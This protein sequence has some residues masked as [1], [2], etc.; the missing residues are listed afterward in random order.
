MGLALVSVMIYPDKTE[1]HNKK[2]CKA[3]EAR[4]GTRRYAV[5]HRV[6][7]KCHTRFSFTIPAYPRS[8]DPANLAG[9]RSY[10]SQ[11]CIS[12]IIFT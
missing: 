3:R 2:G 7:P 10:S 1:M 8:L 9:M 11:L 12:G 4:S 6:R 5:V